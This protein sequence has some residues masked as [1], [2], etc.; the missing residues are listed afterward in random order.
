MPHG[1]L[2]GV[3]RAPRG[4]P[5][6]SF[7]SAQ[8]SAE[9]HVSGHTS[10]TVS[11]ARHV[12]SIP[13]IGLHWAQHHGARSIN[14][15]QSGVFGIS[16]SA[17]SQRLRLPMM[18][19][20]ISRC[21]F[22][23]RRNYTQ[24]SVHTFRHTCWLLREYFPRGVPRV[25][26]AAVR[27]RLQY[28]FA[29]P[30]S[31]DGNRHSQYDSRR[32]RNVRSEFGTLSDSLRFRATFDKQCHPSPGCTSFAFEEPLLP[33]IG[34]Y[35]SGI[36]AGHSGAHSPGESLSCIAAQRLRTTTFGTWFRAS[37]TTATRV[38]TQSRA[39]AYDHCAKYG[40]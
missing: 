37:G 38:P 27:F 24:H 28:A 26:T 11:A 29:D 2:R 4:V 33:G 13:G 10:A 9:T 23:R 21:R 18:Y 12:Y 14:P 15:I 20:G 3:L 6:E 17:S 19:S 7:G 39:G 25:A 34:L 32:Q 5:Q 36:C 31:Y 35:I 30:G 8:C 1:V 40:K 16:G 22:T